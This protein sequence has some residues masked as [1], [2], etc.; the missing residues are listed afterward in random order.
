[1]IRPKC[2]TTIKSKRKYFPI[3]VE[4][5]RDQFEYGGKKYAQS[6]EKEA[7]DLICEAWGMEWRLGEMNKRL[8]RF[9][10]LQREKDMLKLAVEAFLVW[11]QMGFHLLKDNA[12]DTDTGNEKIKRHRKKSILDKEN[13]TQTRKKKVL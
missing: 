10:N 11:L 4:L 1:M 3:F 8:L 6:E 13:E 7:T 2:V 5:M 12:H 9:K